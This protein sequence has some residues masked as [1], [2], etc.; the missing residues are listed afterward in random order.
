MKLVPG[1]VTV[2]SAAREIGLWFPDL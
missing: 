2:E 1:S